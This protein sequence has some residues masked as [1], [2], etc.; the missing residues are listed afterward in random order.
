MFVPPATTVKD[1]TP[2]SHIVLFTGDVVM[3]AGVL[4]VTVAEP[5][6]FADGLLTVHPL[7]SVTLSSVYVVVATGVTVILAP[8]T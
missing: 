1:V 6:R 7:A 3:N 8:L 5:I 4:T 2:Y